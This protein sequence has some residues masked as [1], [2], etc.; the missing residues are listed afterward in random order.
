MTRINCIP[1]E[2]LHDKHLVAEYRELPRVFTL[3][4]NHIKRGKTIPLQSSY[5]M[6][7]GHVLFF[8]D[9]LLWLSLRHQQLVNEM[10]KRGFN[11]KFDQLLQAKFSYI[12]LDYWNMWS[13]TNDDMK[14]N[15]ERIELRLSEMSA[16]SRMKAELDRLRY[17]PV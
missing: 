3:C 15:R 8:Y 12:P 2:E 10:K 11:P 1:V 17:H 9:K 6:G 16:K 14:I 4:A 5:T 13:P 7:K